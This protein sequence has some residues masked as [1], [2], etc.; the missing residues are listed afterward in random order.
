MVNCTKQGPTVLCIGCH[1]MIFNCAIYQAKVKNLIQNCIILKGSVKFIAHIF[2]FPT[3][4]HLKIHKKFTIEMMPVS[5]LFLLR[6]TTFGFQDHLARL[7]LIKILK[8]RLLSYRS[9]LKL[10]VNYRSRAIGSWQSSPYSFPYTIKLI[11]QAMMGL[12][13]A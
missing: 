10:K 5:T 4:L 12:V 3:I 9:A 1:S 7:S 11:K 8:V 2:A 6:C 13:F